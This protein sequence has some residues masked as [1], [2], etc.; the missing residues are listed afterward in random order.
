MTGFVLGWQPLGNERCVCCRTG[1]SLVN[2]C[3]FSYG[4]FCLPCC[5]HV[6]LF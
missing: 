1:I 2:L 3:G 5:L 6:M 4:V